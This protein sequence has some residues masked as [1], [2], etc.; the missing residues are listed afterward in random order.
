[1]KCE[2]CERLDAILRLKDNIYVCRKHIREE[3]PRR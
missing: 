3:L 1:M 2:F